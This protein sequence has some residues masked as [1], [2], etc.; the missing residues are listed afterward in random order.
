MLEKA[1]AKGV[2][3][4]FDETLPTTKQSRQSERQKKR[5]RHELKAAIIMIII[6]IVL[7]ETCEILFE[8]LWKRKAWVNS[9][10]RTQANQRKKQSLK[11]SRALSELLRIFP[12]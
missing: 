1:P 3:S 4:C 9:L 12:D 7:S 8:G 6:I 10:Q 11:K 5:K 2:S